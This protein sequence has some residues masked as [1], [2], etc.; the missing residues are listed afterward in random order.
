MKTVMHKTFAVSLLSLILAGCTAGAA[1]NNG[2]PTV[3]PL[4][5]AVTEVKQGRITATSSASG[6]IE[7]HLSVSV[8]AKVP[9]R[10]IAVHKEMGDA[11]VE[12]E[13]LVELEDR[14]A[15]AQFSQAQAQLAQAEAQSR[16]A[17]QQLHRLSD[18]LKV[19]AVSKQQVESVETQASLAAAQVRAARASVDLAGA[20]LERTQ[21][22]APATGVLATRSVEPGA[23]VGT[24]ST[25]FQ[26]VDLTTVVVRAG[27]AERDINAV[28]VGSDVQVMV[29]AL[30]KPFAGK[31]EAL[32]PNMDRQTRTYQVKVTLDNADGVL[33]GGMFAQVRFAVR[34][35][36]GIL[37]P[38]EALV[39]RNGEQ[40]VFVVE[41][42]TARLQKVTV[43][44]TADDQASV[45]GVAVGASVVTAGQNSLYDGAPVILGRGG[46][47]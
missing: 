34:E 22:T 44:V 27:V 9:G 42:E 18:L 12:G 3:Q 26:L 6:Q 40:H 8:T 7:P 13:L 32:S 14:D 19:G 36:E 23:L 1:K 20:N 35:E 41:G 28:H 38:V 29:P 4:P 46:A 16:E 5:V 31:V 33:K 10:V 24:G 39:E 15:A 21:V 43:L 47:Q 11:V 45:E 25:L 37:I 30:G 17:E 2:G